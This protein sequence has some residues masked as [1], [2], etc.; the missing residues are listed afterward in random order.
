V[1]G[2]L[3]SDRRAESTAIA[4]GALSRMPKLVFALAVLL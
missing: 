4:T 2:V 3:L 1:L